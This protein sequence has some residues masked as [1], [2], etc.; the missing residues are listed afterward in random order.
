MGPISSKFSPHKRR[1]SSEKRE[2][3]G[4]LDTTGLIG[5][6]PCPQ[7]GHNL[8][9]RKSP[10]ADCFHQPSRACVRTS[11]S[12]DRSI[13]RASLPSPVGC[14]SLPPRNSDASAAREGK[15]SG[16][17]RTNATSLGPARHPSLPPPPLPLIPVSA[18]SVTVP[19]L[20][21]S[22]LSV[23][24]LRDWEVARDGGAAGEGSG[25]LRLPHQ[26]ASH[27]RQR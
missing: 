23:V 4:L 20:I 8:H 24:V 11:P 6:V 9:S 18:A 1:P 12:S 15:R 7:D 25:R 10:K 27:R 19:D 13:D 22:L 21:W 17:S 16:R 26:A 14:P 5:Q 3:G 2:S